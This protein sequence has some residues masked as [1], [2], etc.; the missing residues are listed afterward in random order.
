LATQPDRIERSQHELVLQLPLGEL[1]M[2]AKGMAAPEVGE[3]Y[4]RALALYY[5]LGETPQ[6]FPV[7][8]GLYRFHEAQARLS[9]AAELAQQLFDLAKRQP[10]MGLLG[11]GHSALGSVV[12]FHGDLVAARVHLEHSLRL[13]DTWQP[14]P[15]TFG[16]ADADPL[17]GG[18]R[19]RRPSHPDLP[20]GR[21]RPM[22]ASTAT[23]APG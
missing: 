17:R 14:S 6:S 10:D 16:G 19:D 15:Q 18:Q 5:Q 7:L 21:A 11:E 4:T 23:M 20:P 12:L 8:Q 9:T 3:I 13:S 1:L 22:N 2:A